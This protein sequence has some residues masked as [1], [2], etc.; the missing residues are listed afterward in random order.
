MYW[1]PPLL[2]TTFTVPPAARPYSAENPL[3]MTWNSCTA[4]WLKVDRTEPV[5]AS[6]LSMPSTM[7]LLDRGFTPAK[8]RPE[9]AAAPLLSGLLAVATP[10]VVRLKSSKRRRLMGRLLM[11][12]L[13]ITV[14][15]WVR[16][17]STRVFSPMTSTVA[18]AS[19]PARSALNSMVVPKRSTRSFTRL[20]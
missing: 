17:G 18:A 1:L 6:L 10:G 12:L 9:F 20:L 13:S 2:V 3:G 11:K 7:T 14:E 4:S 19:T 15:T 8:V 5:E 16:V